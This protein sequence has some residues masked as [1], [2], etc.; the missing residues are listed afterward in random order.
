MTKRPSPPPSPSSPEPSNREKMK[1][2]VHEL[3]SQVAEKKAQTQADV[4]EEK[5][6]GTRR[7]RTRYVQAAV[8]FVVLVASIVFMLPR[9]RQPFEPPSGAAAEH[10]ARQA[11]VFASTLVDRY[12]ARSGRLPGSF[13]QVGVAIPGLTYTVTGSSYVLSMN[14]EGRDIVFHKGDDIAHFLSSSGDRR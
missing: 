9:W 8:L 5:Q 6:R 3:M 2:A 11:V 1:D 7:Q 13:N 14:V 4:V 12:E 10:D